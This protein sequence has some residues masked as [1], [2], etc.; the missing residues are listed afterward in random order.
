MLRDLLSGMLATSGRRTI[1]AVVAVAIVIVAVYFLAFSSGG[2]KVAK[3]SPFRSQAAAAQSTSLD[4]LTL[5]SNT[6]SKGTGSSGG[7][8]VIDPTGNDGFGSGPGSAIASDAV[9]VDGSSGGVAQ[10]LANTGSAS[11]GSSGASNS[12]SSG[13]VATATPSGSSAPT[14]T[15]APGQPT[16]TPAPPTATLAPGQPT[17]TTEPA[18][19]T[20]VPA[21]D[22]HECC[23]TADRH[24]RAAHCYYGRTANVDFDPRHEYAAS[25]RY[26]A[27]DCDA[28]TDTFADADLRQRTSS[29]QLELPERYTWQ[30]FEHYALGEPLRM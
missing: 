30:R 22:Q 20:N 17:P 26:H 25:D 6:G 7:S 5:P 1:S 11:N 8:N 3:N 19:A 14:A 28:F 4:K 12:G 23:L 24:A 18:T 10:A 15:L 9:Q 29:S 21:G 27:A 16:Y 2:S 13:A